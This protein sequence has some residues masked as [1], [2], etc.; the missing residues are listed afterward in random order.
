[1]ITIRPCRIRWIVLHHVEVK[2][3]QNFNRRERSAR[4]A[5]LGGRNHLD[6]LTS[7]CAANGLQFL[8][9]LRL[10]HNG[11]T[12]NLARRTYATQSKNGGQLV[13]AMVT[14]ARSPI[15]I[16]LGR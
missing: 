14:P 13:A 16:R 3:H 10:F 8:D 11:I 7:S 9:V 15:K 2:S 5:R 1:M 12:F 6:D 4:M